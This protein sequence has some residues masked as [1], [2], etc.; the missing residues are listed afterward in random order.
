MRGLIRQSDLDAYLD[1][2]LPSEEM[3]R[4]EQALRD[5]PELL[6][7]LAT[8]NTRRDTGVHSL[9]AIWRRHRLSCLTREQLGSYLLGVL[10]GEMASYV[11]FHLRTIGCR[12]CQANLA[13]LEKQQAETP[14]VVESRR[15]KFFQSSAGY[16][17]PESRE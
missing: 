7:R 15:R 8:I 6:Q 3:T 13:D 16:L 10:S 1:E 12:Y 2:A 17:R 14:E 5:N 11:D 4:I 9:G